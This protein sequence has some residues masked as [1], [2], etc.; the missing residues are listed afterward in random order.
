MTK[1]ELHYKKLSIPLKAMLFTM[2]ALGALY[3]VTDLVIEFVGDEIVNF[4]KRR[5]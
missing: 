1:N 2:G 5:L 4:A 3:I